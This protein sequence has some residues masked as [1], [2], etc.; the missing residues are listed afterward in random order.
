MNR[1]QKPPKRHLK[2]L[3]QLDAAVPTSFPELV[4]KM[5]G[6]PRTDGKPPYNDLLI[7]VEL[8][9]MRESSSVLYTRDGILLSPGGQ[10]DL[11]SHQRA[12]QRGRWSEVRQQ[13]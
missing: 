11:E 10:R 2:I 6:V 13:Q 8:K 5:K 12:I 9:E 7:G 4:E 1:D 3:G